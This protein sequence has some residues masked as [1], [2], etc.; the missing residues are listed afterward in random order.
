MSRK[1][2]KSS[3]PKKHRAGASAASHEE[4][5]QPLLEAE[6]ARSIFAV[7]VFVASMLS[8]L[9]ILGFAGKFGTYGNKV[10]T[11][12]FGWGMY[13]VP[14]LLIGFGIFMLR[15]RSARYKTTTIVGLVTFVL[16]LFGLIH[17][18]V[19][20]QG[21][22]VIQ[23][24]RG[25]GYVGFVLSY[26]LYV[27]FGLTATYL[28]LFSFLVVSVLLIFNIS[29]HQIMAGAQRLFGKK[30]EAAAGEEKDTLVVQGM[31][32]QAVAAKVS[33]QKQ[34][35]AAADQRP[36]EVKL[37]AREA[38]VRPLTSG[39]FTKKPVDSAKPVTGALRSKIDTNWT[40]P[41]V[42]L[43]DGALSQPTSG[44]IKE[45]A[46]IIKQTLENFGISV[47]MGAVSVG[48]TVTQYTLRPAV[49]VKL[50]QIIALQ[51]DLALALAAHPI[52]VEAPIP[53]KSLVGIEV[54]NQSVAMVRLREILESKEFINRK[55]PLS[56]ALGRDVAGS[57]VIAELQK[58]PHMLIG[59][60]TGSGKSVCINTLIVSLLYQNSPSELKLILVD[61]KRVE[62]TYYNDIPHLLT[63]VITE[64]KKTIFALKWAVGEMERRYKLLSETGKR[65]IAS[66][67][68]TSPDRL[69]YI[70]IVIDELADLM[71][72]AAA[73][74]EAAIVR[75]AQMARAVGI[76]LIVAT[77][78]PSVD[79]ITGLIKANIT[80]R[81]AFSVASQIDSRTM[82][83]SA[84]AEKL[85]GNGD[86]LFLTTE[87][88]KPKRVQGA[89]LSEQ[90]VRAF[91]DFLHKAGAPDYNQQIVEPK[92]N[93]PQ[94]GGISSEPGFGDDN[95]V[96]DDMFEQAKEVVI[97]G[98]KGSAS[99]L[100]RRL[101][102]GYARA[103]R[104]LD[105]LEEQ[106]IV[107]PPDGSR[108]R[109]VLVKEDALG[110]GHGGSLDEP[111]DPRDQ[112]ITD[113]ENRETF[114][115]SDEAV[116]EPEEQE[117]MPASEPESVPE[118]APQQDDTPKNPS[119]DKGS[120]N[121]SWG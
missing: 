97:R 3:K 52:R 61:P 62:L 40:P 47:E 102:V 59:G 67:N 31:R 78:R 85:L 14:L 38:Q 108:P 112:A 24:G 9:S 35:T 103:A 30:P 32:P 20:S 71:S 70:V 86:M 63:P 104:L 33:Q 22:E 34:S 10:L 94:F 53:G 99:L 45:N 79:V 64:P 95:G 11:L 69:P 93:G 114:A 58:M 7:G 92:S 82:I 25:G 91:T 43:L 8:L 106:G 12:F 98:G 72:V 13:V 73:E 121:I 26:S 111:E 89:Y 60:A 21:F 107:G 87:L 68:S 83:D 39:V 55:S 100:Q 75:L 49:G 77:Q 5:R 4:P 54:P 29:L 105:L 50:N 36:K 80:T 41:P 65:D 51:N 81:I 84:G 90:D 28:V 76:H 117:A 23:T 116:A 57:P 118:P 1:P 119:Q 6:V 37:G 18:N 74:V 56:L 88:S 109:E 15:M 19:V 27:I 44:N 96:D 120:G 101:R 16:S 115:S 113:A 48:P 42:D 46:K 17:G 66:Y 110:A 2:K